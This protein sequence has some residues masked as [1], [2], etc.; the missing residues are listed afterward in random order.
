MMVNPLS[1]NSTLPYTRWS[2]ASALRDNPGYSHL[3]YTWMKPVRIPRTLTPAHPAKNPL[4]PAHPGPPIPESTLLH[5]QP[6]HET[7]SRSPSLGHNMGLWPSTTGGKT[8]TSLE[9]KGARCK[10]WALLVTQRPTCQ[11]DAFITHWCQM[12]KGLTQPLPSLRKS[13]PAPDIL[14]S[15]ATVVTWQPTIPNGRNP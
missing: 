6:A 9:R 3:V 1:Q 14:P 2:S 10:S 4:F 11:V 8:A 12:W 13:L 7:D 5:A 15:Q